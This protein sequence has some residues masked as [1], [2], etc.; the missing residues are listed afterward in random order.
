[1]S[2]ET[3]ILVSDE[4]DQNLSSLDMRLWGMVYWV[5]ANYHTQIMFKWSSIHVPER[6]N[7]WIRFFVPRDSPHRYEIVTYLKGQLDDMAREPHT[8][9]LRDSEEKH[10]WPGTDTEISITVYT[11]RGVGPTLPRE[12]EV[13][14]TQ[15]FIKMVKMEMG[16]LKHRER[17]HLKAL[18]KAKQDPDFLENLVKSVSVTKLNEL[19]GDKS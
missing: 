6:R 12:F 14:T 5:A 4:G 3:E 8:Y 19:L 11:F 7:E 13:A 15:E 10:Y 17:T 18:D 16:T 2:R 9:N 1:M